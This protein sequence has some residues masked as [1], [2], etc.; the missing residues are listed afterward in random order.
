MKR[1]PFGD[2]TTSRRLGLLMAV[3]AIGWL[4][5]GIVGLAKEQGG[6]AGFGLGLFV[7]FGICAWWLSPARIT[8]RGDKL[9]GS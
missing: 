5:A 4:V 1:R 7:F 9:R 2:L 3:L 8:R 6:L